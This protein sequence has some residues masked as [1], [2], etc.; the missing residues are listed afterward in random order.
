MGI[1]IRSKLQLPSF[2]GFEAM[3]NINEYKYIK[4]N[5]KWICRT[6][7]SFEFCYNLSFKFSITHFAHPIFFFSK[8]QSFLNTNYFHLCIFYLKIFNH[9][10]PWSCCPP[11]GQYPQ[12]S[13]SHLLLQ[14]P[15]QLY[16]TES[17]HCK[18]ICLLSLFC[19]SNETKRDRQSF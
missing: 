17:V 13:F 16:M 12:A 9:K 7:L 4:K 1:N 14:V 15:L 3:I 5:Y 19:L 10:P 11:T 18:I 2:I 6:P 8:S